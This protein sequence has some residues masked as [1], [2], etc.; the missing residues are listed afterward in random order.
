MNKNNFFQTLTR[1][2]PLT[3]LSKIGLTIIL[4]II[5]LANAGKITTPDNLF[6]AP[7][8]S[9]I[10]VF[11]GVLVHF[12]FKK[13]ELY[14]TLPNSNSGFTAI[15]FAIISIVELFLFMSSVIFLMFVFSF[16]GTY[17]ALELGV[18]SIYSGFGVLFLAQTLSE[19]KKIRELRNKSF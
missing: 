3:L 13:S 5:Y 15:P 17:S 16:M 8:L 2:I 18:L 4:L 7:F 19:M 1:K 12:L 9:L 6:F 10:F 14:L 11:M